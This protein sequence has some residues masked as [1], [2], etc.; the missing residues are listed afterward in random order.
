[1]T[2]FRTGKGRAQLLPLS[3]VGGRNSQHGNVFP[4]KI[5]DAYVNSPPTKGG[6]R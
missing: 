6:Y 4:V 5:W 3:G 2:L 1:V